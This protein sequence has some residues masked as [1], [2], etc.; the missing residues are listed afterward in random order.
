VP[1]QPTDSIAT[2][3][4]NRQVSEA[5][6]LGTISSSYYTG[7]TLGVPD[8]AGPATIIRQPH[9]RK[10]FDTATVRW[11]GGDNWT[12]NPTVK[13]KRRV[14]HKWVNYADQSGQIQTVLDR[15][16]AVSSEALNHYTGK[17]RW[18]W[19]AN[20]EVFDSY[21][22]ADVP[23]GQVP[24]GRYRFVINGNIHRSGQARPYRLKSK[25][26]TVRPWNGLQVRRLRVTRHKASFG[27]APIRYPRLPIH[28]PAALKFYSDDKG[29]KPG[30]SLICMTCSFQPWATTSHVVSAAV[31]IRHAGK[32]LRRIPATYSLSTHRWSAP[33]TALRK[34]QRVVIARGGVRDA[35]GEINGHRVRL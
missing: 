28:V 21:P 9:N 2:A 19:T 30:H 18:T 22:R 6:V 25:P 29:G 12:D 34:H 26:F 5:Q 35:Y 27:V 11:V 17:Q 31:E 8:S 33:I 10:R 4:E 23:G 16:P 1:T 32:V 14:N 7:W 24:D 15:R 20:F 13:V 3:D